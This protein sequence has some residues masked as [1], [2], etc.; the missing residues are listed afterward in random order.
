MDEPHIDPPR[1]RRSRRFKRTVAVIAAAPLAAGGMLLALNESAQAAGP[2]FPAHY[3][4]PYLQIS[5]SDQGDMIADMNASGDKYYTLAF[6]IPQSGCTPQLEDG[7]YGL[8]QF[9]SQISQLQSAGG[10]VIISSGGAS[11]GELAQTCTNVS[12]LTSAYA[13]IVNSTGVTRLDFD[14]E[15]SR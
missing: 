8:T 14:I 10:Q 2:A 11:G 9:N 4:A 13:N 6:L 5:T 3:A 15:G 7:G 1:P 12:S